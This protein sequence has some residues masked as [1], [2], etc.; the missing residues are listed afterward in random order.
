M[1]LLRT[2]RL[3]TIRN[4]TSSEL[5]TAAIER[6]KERF[7]SND[8]PVAEHYCKNGSSSRKKDRR[9]D[10]GKVIYLR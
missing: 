7:I 3:R 9:K 10:N 4:C 5:E 2:E 6:H 8:Y 1:A